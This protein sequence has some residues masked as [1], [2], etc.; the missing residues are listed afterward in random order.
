MNTYI[1]NGIIGWNFI[2]IIFIASLSAI[3]VGNVYKFG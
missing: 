1:I 3:S 2:I